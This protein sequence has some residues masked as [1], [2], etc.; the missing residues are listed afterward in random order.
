M[1]TQPI[2]D[3]APPP[4]SALLTAAVV[5]QRSTRRATA[6]RAS[7][8]RATARQYKDDID[9]RIFEDVKDHPQ[10]TTGDMAKRL[11]ANRGTIAAEISHMMRSGELT[12]EPGSRTL[13]ATE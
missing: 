1:Q 4:E 3:G 10:S 8:R 11:N 6:R 12:R 9:G 2:V 5:P 13:S 7:N